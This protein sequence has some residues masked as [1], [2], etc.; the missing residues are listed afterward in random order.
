MC[1]RNILR[2]DA[3][4]VLCEQAKVV[5]VSDLVHDAEFRLEASGN[6]VTFYDY[7][8]FPISVRVAL[9]AAID[10][11]TFKWTRERDVV[12]LRIIEATIR[13]GMADPILARFNDIFCAR[14]SV[15]ARFRSVRAALLG[16]VR[17]AAARHQHYARLLESERPDVVLLTHPYTWEERLLTPALRSHRIQ[18]VAAIHS[19][20]NPTTH[21][22]ML[23]R[24]DRVLVWN[25][26]LKA[27]MIRLY[28]YSAEDILCT[29]MPQLDSYVRG[30][31][32]VDRGEFM[33]PLGLDPARR[34]ITYACG[35]PEFVPG[36]DRIVTHLARVVA[37]DRLIAPASLVVRLHPGREA[38]ELHAIGELP[39]VRIDRPSVA[40]SAN[41]ARAGWH[42][43]RSD[44]RHFVNLLRHSDVFINAFST[45]TIEAAAADVPI[46]NVAFDGDGPRPYHAS[47]RKHYDW[48]H[49]AH[50]VRSGGV[51]LARSY[52]DL[53][54]AVQECLQDPALLREGRK[55]ITREQCGPL[56]GHAGL[57]IAQAVLSRIVANR[58]AV[59]EEDA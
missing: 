29:G 22:V 54:A 1:A 36:Q 50:I 37:E 45:T 10:A 24:Y 35:A 18:T 46:V 53:T 2:S 20:D 11:E 14:S 15:L 17:R 49:Y 43:D 28:D 56:D 58:S 51:R 44:E 38:G 12:T 27:Q 33:R 23:E 40:Y 26:I 7:A 9:R 34:L 47:L 57:R 59:T 21:P 48:E 19:W 5:V 4:N 8:T 42:Q 3:W 31:L 30:E 55:R 13:A 6:G 25:D 32:N 41:Y 52:D 16:F 39:H